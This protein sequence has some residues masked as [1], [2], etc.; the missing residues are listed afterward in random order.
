M[1]LTNFKC[2]KKERS[3][4]WELGVT[5]LFATIFTG[6]LLLALV[7]GFG[8]MKCPTGKY[9]SDHMCYDCSITLGDLCADCNDPMACT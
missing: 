1:F 8:L 5:T 4:N 9:A 6:A 3:K 2:F 7:Y